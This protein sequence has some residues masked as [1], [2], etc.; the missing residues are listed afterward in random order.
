MAA[1]ISEY[2]G[3][4][5]SREV[6]AVEIVEAADKGEQATNMILWR[7]QPMVHVRWQQSR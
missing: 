5:S 1:D 6:A 4:S 7:Q 2:C 3:D